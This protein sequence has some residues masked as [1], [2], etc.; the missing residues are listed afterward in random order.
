M[1]VGWLP[2]GRCCLAATTTHCLLVLLCLVA[3]FDIRRSPEDEAVAALRSESRQSGRAMQFTASSVARLLG[4]LTTL[5]TSVKRGLGF[6]GPAL[7]WTCLNHIFFK[8]LVSILTICLSNR[9]S[10]LQ[11]FYLNHMFVFC[12]TNCLLNHM[13]VSPLTIFYGYMVNDL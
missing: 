4:P 5:F 3:D 11:Y 10:S 8:K 6:S 1:C 9:F 12:L 2:R 7:I 13:F